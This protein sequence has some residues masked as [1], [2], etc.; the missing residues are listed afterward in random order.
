MATANLVQT[1]VS[2]GTQ[3]ALALQGDG[4]FFPK[5]STASRLALTLTTTDKGFIVY[6]TTD[7]NIYFWNG[8]AWES[9]PGSGDAGANGSVQYN[10]NGI[11][12][13]A[14][15]FVYTKATSAV[16]IAGDLT[17]ATD[18]FKVI[19]ATKDVCI[20][21][22]TP[23]FNNKLTVVGGAGGDA[24]ITSGNGTRTGYIGTDGTTVIMGGYS[25]HT[26]R[27][28]AND[29]P[30]MQIAP[31][32]IFDWYDGAASPGT[33]MTLN[34]TGLGIGIAPD[35]AKATRLSVY[36]TGDLTDET[37]PFSVGNTAGGMRLYAGVNNTNE[38]VYIGSV[39][40]GTGY[41]SL[42]LQPNGGN[43]GVGVSTF[44]TSAA[45]VLGLANATAP[46]TSPAGMG[47]LYVEAGALKFRGSG[48]TVT[49]IAVA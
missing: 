49:T 29:L 36:Q 1:S 28:H 45:K 2:G 39:K 41:R 32:G 42:I 27:I 15:D 25:N 19:S 21:T 5:A 48:G 24:F 13:G 47:Q 46:T 14:S 44:G 34:S 17:V 31:L 23:T 20:G 37:A 3:N 26:L 43:V 40:S 18:A 9:I 6:D 8:S 38:Y 11:V 22:V 33:R 35:S 4:V 16:S 12:S 10:D 7:S 30:Q